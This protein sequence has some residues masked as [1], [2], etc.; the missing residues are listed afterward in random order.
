MKF[1]FLLFLTTSLTSMLYCQSENQVPSN[2]R[3]G[4]E[5]G[6]GFNSVENFD[7]ELTD[8]SFD[9]PAEYFGILMK[10]GK[11]SSV[12]SLSSGLRLQG[13]NDSYYV[14]ST[15]LILPLEIEINTLPSRKLSPFFRLG[16]AP[17]INLHTD[18]RSFEPNTVDLSYRFG[19]GLRLK[20]IRNH[21]VTIQCMRVISNYSYDQQRS[22]PG[23]AHYILYANNS[24]LEFG[25]SILKTIFHSQK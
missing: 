12:F 18:S 25:F 11:L 3:I 14:S 8:I 24:T 1:T 7:I 19:L 17:E 5:A 10:Y 21:E 20:N 6:I 16:L 23:G 4:I 13:K 9:S 15:Y 2:F 22:S